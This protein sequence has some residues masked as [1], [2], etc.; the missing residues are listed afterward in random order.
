MARLMKPVELD[1]Y[2]IHQAPLSMARVV[3]SD[4]NFYDRCYLNAHD[5]T[6]DIFFIAGL[7]HYPNLGVK[8]AFATVRRG[9]RQ[10]ALRLSDALDSRTTEQAVGPFRIEVVEPL[11][12]LRLV[13]EA[14][15]I[16]FDL[17]WDA[18]FPAILEQPHLLLA[19]NKP[20]LDAERFAQL[21]SW[22]GTLHVDGDE[23]EV[24]PDT[25]LG[26]RD[27]SWG[28][29][30]SGDADPPG[31]SDERP[32]E[33]FWWLYVPLRFD[34]FAL[35]VIIQEEPDGYRS[36]NDARRVFADGRIEQLGWPRVEI[37]YRSD[38]R[39]P[40]R[41]RLHLTTPAGEPLLVEVETLSFI[42][43]HV[44]TGYGGDP[45]WSHGQWKGHAWSSASGYD[46]TD[47]EIVARIPWG[48]SDHVARATCAGQ[49]GWG[50]F[51]H[52]AMGRH[53]PSG[54]ADWSSVAP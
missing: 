28:I 13:C 48:I 49:T 3:T 21:G 46:L 11:R 15:P 43:L 19:G 52:A 34:D 25:W 7:G 2:P 10:W 44:G 14:D 29:R 50:M 12:R 17:T 8:D 9:D 42:P 45:E 30:P 35:V 24:D 6:G 23:I 51:E 5:R 27:R 32:L 26:A 37:D 38:G 39:H 18:S 33:G 22:T 4:K 41:A 47:P 16:G 40:E 36:L 31:R 54:F 20:T 1:E 53:D